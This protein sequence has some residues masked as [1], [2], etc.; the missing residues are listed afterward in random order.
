MQPQYDG[1]SRCSELHWLPVKSIEVINSFFY[2]KIP[3]YCLIRRGG[4]WGV[5]RLGLSRPVLPRAGAGCPNRLLSLPLQLGGVGPARTAHDYQYEPDYEQCREG[6][7]VEQIIDC[8]QR[9]SQ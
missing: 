3:R 6:L 4:E 7:I 1:H 2:P 8:Q 5:P 9:G